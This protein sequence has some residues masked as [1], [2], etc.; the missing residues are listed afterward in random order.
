MRQLP[1]K[2]RKIHQKEV[3]EAVLTLTLTMCHLIE[4]NKSIIFDVSSCTQV[5]TQALEMRENFQKQLQEI[6]T[7]TSLTKLQRQRSS[8][9]RNGCDNSPATPDG[10]RS[11][12]NGRSKVLEALR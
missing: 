1:Q 6:M 10:H 11:M 8:L 12:R 3:I 7:A 5:L 4:C 2:K 9:S